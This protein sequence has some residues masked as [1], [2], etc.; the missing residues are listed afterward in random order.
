[1]YRPVYTK[2]FERDVKKIS[3]SGSKDK[4]KL[5]LLINTLISGKKLETHYN[6]H[7]LFNNW[8]DHYECHIKPDWLLIYKIDKPKKEIYFIRTGSHS[9]LF[10]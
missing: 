4:N 10:K 1:M 6:N 8:K 7:L 5:T 3:K 2:Q 9:E